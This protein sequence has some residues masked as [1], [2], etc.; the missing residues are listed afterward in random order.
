MIC[1]Q[2]KSTDG[3]SEKPK[4]MCK[5]LREDLHKDI[6]TTVQLTEQEKAIL[7]ARPSDEPDKSTRIRRVKTDES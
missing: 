3:P 7:G 4:D 6:E 1:E 2:E 5:D